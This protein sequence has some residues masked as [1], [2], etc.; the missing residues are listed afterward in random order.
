MMDRRTF[1]Q[2]AAAAGGLWATYPRA[3]A[4]LEDAQVPAELGVQLYTLRSIFPDDFVGVLEALRHIGYT[5]VEFAGYHGR[6]PEVVRAVLDDVGLTAPSV[7]V[8]LPEL[9]GST[10]AVLEAARVVGHRYIVMPFLDP[11]ARTSLDDYR[12]IADTLNRL[13]ER[14]KDAGLALGYHNHDFEFETFGGSESGFDVLLDRTDPELV[15]IEM[16]LFWTV[17]AGADPLAYFRSHPGR[18]RLFHVKD[19]SRGGDMR[20][21]GDGSIDFA[22]LFAQAEAAG[23]QYAFVEHDNPSD[24]LESVRNSFEHLSALRARG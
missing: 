22:A 24:P 23:L 14:V 5:Q 19:R 12:A 15:S 3:L 6:A 2:R 18:F 9:E 7:H 20:D 13:G 16:D 11:S 8:G 21:V 17:H 10:D 1:V 4:A